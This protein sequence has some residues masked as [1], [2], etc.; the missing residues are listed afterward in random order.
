MTTT[1]EALQPPGSVPS[2]ESPPAAALHHDGTRCDG[3]CRECQAAILACVRR[4]ADW[5]VQ[6]DAQACEIIAL[7]CN[8]WGE[9]YVNIRHS[10]ARRVWPDR[11]FEFDDIGYATFDDEGLSV[12]VSKDREA[13]Q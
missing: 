3:P 2:A 4:L 8:A 6:H 7:S 9:P 11:T 10:L 1:L 12:A 5:I 13:V